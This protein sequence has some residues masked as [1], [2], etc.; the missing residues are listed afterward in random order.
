MNK[1]KWL[2]IVNVILPILVLW[3][4]GTALLHDV[5]HENFEKVHPIAG[6]LLVVCV[7]IHLILNWSWVKTAYCKKG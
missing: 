6:L 2:K 7:V 5:L 4:L 1:Q 3:L